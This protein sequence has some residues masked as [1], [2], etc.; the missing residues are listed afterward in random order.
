MDSF[1][2]I[3]VLIEVRLRALGINRA[4]LVQRLGY[5]NIAKGL[6][7]LEN[8]CHGDLDRYPD[9]VRAL[10][11]A[12]DIPEEEVARAIRESRAALEG[13]ARTDKEAQEALYR[14]NFRPHAVILTERSRPSPIFAAALLG[15]DKLL[16]LEVD[17]SLPRHT[18]L[19]QAVDMLPEQVPTFGKPVG[20]A[21]NYSPDMA[22]E[23]DLQTMDVKTLS[24]AVRLPHASLVMR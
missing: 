6:R 20:V 15:V 16:R 9:L 11:G 14:R 10:A 12:L 22:V 23:L 1:L 5:A 21:M 7:N 3:A 17:I 2:P 8:L 24:A 13:A 4:A 19:Q 18:W